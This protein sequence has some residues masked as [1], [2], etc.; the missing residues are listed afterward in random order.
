MSYNL[1]LFRNDINNLIFWAKRHKNAK[2]SNLIEKIMT[3][4]VKN[5]D[6]FINKVSLEAKNLYKM[7]GEVA[8]EFHR[9]KGW[10]HFELFPEMILMSTINSEHDIY[11]LLL[12]FFC[13][14]FPEFF[15]CL[16]NKFQIYLGTKKTDIKINYRRFKK[17]FYI[18]NEKE[19]DTFLKFIKKNTSKRIN[20][21]K[22][23]KNDWKYYYNSQYIQEKRNVKFAKNLMP[24]KMQKILNLDHEFNIFKK[25]ER[26]TIKKITDYFE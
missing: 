11:D 19:F 21:G 25:E 26:K 15:I 12:G 17:K 13:N 5:P 22:F 8:T 2:N 14:R 6:L 23:S 1:K 20:L 16:K 18:L 4:Y 24:L 9:V 7:A 10:A 3:N